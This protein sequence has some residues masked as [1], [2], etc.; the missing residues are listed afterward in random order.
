ML[1]F[2]TMNILANVQAYL[3]KW[4][5]FEETLIENSPV[6]YFFIIIIFYLKKIPFNSPVF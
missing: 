1:T 2:H 4:T 6:F 5:F 3:M